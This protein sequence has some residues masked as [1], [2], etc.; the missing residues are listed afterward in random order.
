MVL[1]LLILTGG[2]I[3]CQTPDPK[4]KPNPDDPTQPTGKGDA[5]LMECPEVKAQKG[6]YFI[7]HYVEQGKRVNY[8]LLYDVN[9]HHS[10]WVCFSFDKV[11]ARKN[12][13]RNTAWA[14]DP[15][16]P[17]KYAVGHSDFK[18][19][20]R[21]HLVA[22]NDR[23][24][25]VEAN[26]QTFYYS[27]MSP[28]YS[29]FNRKAWQQL[30]ATVQRWARGDIKGKEIYQASIADKLYI[31]KGGTI[32]NEGIYPQRT[33]GN[34]VI[35]KDYWMAILAEKDGSY[36]ALGFWISHE[37]KEA[38]P[39]GVKSLVCSVDELEQRTGIN[40]FPNLNDDVEE[41]VESRDPL[42]EEAFWFEK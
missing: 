8:S 42:Q 26:K 21:G 31:A 14:W 34:I 13:S 7:T 40:F 15:F 3:R 19:F 2:F 25:S 22:S 24:Y 36:H 1:T 9:K 41:K 18:G 33:E 12:V 23:V 32:N 10:V 37:A 4:P 29:D 35:P 38:L 17:A 27:N 11:T 30:E 6:Q 20:D 28:Q 39:E 16:I 5:S